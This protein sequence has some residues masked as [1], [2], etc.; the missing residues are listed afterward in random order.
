MS[1]AL[2]IHSLITS[3]TALPTPLPPLTLDSDE[4]TPLHT[5]STSKN[6]AALTV[7]SPLTRT[8]A[9]PEDWTPIHI[10]ASNGFIEGLAVLL[11]NHPT[12]VNDQTESGQSALHF[13]V[14]KGWNEI[15]VALLDAGADPNLPDKYG[16]TSIHR[17]VHRSRYDIL[18]ILVDSGGNINAAD[19]EGAT[20]L[21]G[22]AE[23][24][25]EQMVRAL[26]EKGAD[27]GRVDKSGRRAV[28][29]AA[30]SVKRLVSVE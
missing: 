21:M 2:D 29:V 19:K 18:N 20:P 1:T 7:L 3:H 26:L 8:L 24:G 14:S 23:E 10:C 17:A 5:A 13:A 11:R 28:D 15:V 25:D 6:L 16:M 9:D 12:H 30:A 4:R 27:V 22:A